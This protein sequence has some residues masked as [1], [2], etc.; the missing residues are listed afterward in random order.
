MTQ[1]IILVVEDDPILRDLA[2]RQLA[3][4]GY[5]SVLLDN[6]EDAVRHDR[7]NVDLIFMDIGLPGIDGT[8]ATLLIREKESLENS[9]RV[10]II[11]LTGHS[12]KQKVLSCGMDDCLQKPALLDDIQK[13]VEKW[14]MLKIETG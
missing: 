14:L 11:A 8:D 5:D 1:P 10:P 4:L 12:D 13:M 7:R 3:K 9:R 2:R 6:G